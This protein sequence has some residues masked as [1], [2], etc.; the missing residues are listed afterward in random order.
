MT[1]DTGG[2]SADEESSTV[3]ALFGELDSEKQ[4]MAYLRGN[5]Y[6]WSDG[7]RVHVWV[8]DRTASAASERAIRAHNGNGGCVALSETWVQLSGPLATLE[9]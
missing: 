1:G 7:N 6:V 2:I 8:L 9:R 3:A 5:T 4:A